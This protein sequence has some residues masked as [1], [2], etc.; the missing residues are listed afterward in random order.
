MSKIGLIILLLFISK[1]EAQTSALAVSDSL[2]AVG[3]YDKAIA[4]L[5]EINSKTEEIHLKLDKN[6]EKPKP[7]FFSIKKF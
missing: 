4:A 6:Y 1:V 5:K 2:Y 3:E 7:Q